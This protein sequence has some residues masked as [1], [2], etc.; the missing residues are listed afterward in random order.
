ML[1]SSRGNTSYCRD[2]A[3]FWDDRRY[4][5]HILT[6]DAEEIYII[7]KWPINAAEIAK[8]IFSSLEQIAIKVLLSRRMPD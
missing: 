4:L 5:Q 3:L 1:P 2:F 7:C 6:K 8:S